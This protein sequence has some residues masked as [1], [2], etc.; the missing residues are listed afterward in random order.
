MIQ[1]RCPWCGPR[2]EIEFS[3]RGDATVRRPAAD[4][5]GEAFYDYVYA[6]RNPRGWHKEWW[7]H[8]HGC[9]Q[10]LQVVRHTLTHEVRAV[11]RAT[12]TIELPQE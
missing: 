1:I 12:D 5:P 11:A 2:D 4:A 7:H 10:Y 9:R 8:S 6:R 3:Y